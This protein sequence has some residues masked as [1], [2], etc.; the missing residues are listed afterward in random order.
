MNLSPVAALGD[1]FLEAVAW[2]REKAP[3]LA[4]RYKEIDAAARQRAFMVA[5]VAQIDVVASVW[6]ALDVALATG[7]PFEEF[8]AAILP[9]V[10]SAWRGSPQQVPARIE[11]IFRTNTAGAYNAGRYQQATHPDTI[12]LRPIWR[13][14]AVL[15]G[16]T[17]DICNACH[18]T[19]LPASHPWWR[20]HL[21]PL[22][23]NCRS[24][25]VTLR[26]GEITLNPPDV[27]AAG[28]F[29]TP[30][31]EA[32]TPDPGQYPAP[33][34]DAV[35]RA[36]EPP[37]APGRIDPRRL[38]ERPI[39][40]DVAPP[41][42]GERAYAKK[43]KA[44]IEA[45]PERMRAAISDF[46]FGYDWVVRRLDRGASPVDILKDLYK[47][48]KNGTVRR[49]DASPEAHL[50]KGAG[51]LHHLRQAYQALPASPGIAYRGLANLTLPQVETLLNQSELTL[52]AIS[53]VSRDPKVA[54]RFAT[55]DKKSGHG[56]LLVI[57]HQGGRAI[58]EGSVFSSEKE[59]LLDGSARFRLVSRH[60]EKGNK[61]RWIVEI[62]QI[63]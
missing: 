1:R 41:P 10:A 59:L 37:P 52:G 44:Q 51:V 29:G 48:W 53:S 13:F 25:F 8:R 54:A 5:G 18:G 16:R 55:S 60:R 6:R 4:E 46:T 22:H 62:E 32:W 28:T 12:R 47:A 63:P 19:T 39:P 45:L 43:N 61:R 24:S 40:V 15:D 7:S 17:S 49:L 26:S 14:D 34:R 33:L 11:T 2:F 57:R 31:G 3:V 21:S 20:T 58:E 23:H 27:A 38:P 35:I 42:E 56:V 36:T 30:P 50:E 9:L